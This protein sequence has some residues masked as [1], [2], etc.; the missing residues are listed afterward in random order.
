MSL[1]EEFMVS[2]VMVVKSRV[3]DGQGGFILTWTDGDSFNAAIV[4]NTTLAARVAEKQGV[5]EVYTITAPKSL[6]LEFGEVV[7][8]VSD[9]AIFRVTSNMVDSETPASATFQFGQVGA[10]KWVLPNG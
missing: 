8:R 2:C 3:P 1:I 5:T 6:G 4:K 7:K 9:G 10:E